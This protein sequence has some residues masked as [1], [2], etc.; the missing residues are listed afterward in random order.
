M[1]PALFTITIGNEELT[2]HQNV[3]TGLFYGITADG[4]HTPVDYD[5]I[6][7][8]TTS[9]ERLKYWRNRFGYTQAELA[10][11]THVSSPTVIMMW[12]NGLRH[13]LR[14]YRQLLNTELCSDIFPD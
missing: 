14:E 8:R 7:T 4:K 9:Q 5:R 12:E 11:L 3:H 6:K 1:A 2:I 10:E 13:P